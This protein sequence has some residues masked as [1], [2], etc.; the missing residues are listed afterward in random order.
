LRIEGYISKT[1]IRRW[2]S[3]YDALAAGDRPADAIP[4][5]SGPKAYDG[6]SGGRLNKI[7]LDDA[8]AQLPRLERACVSCRWIRQ[9]RLADALRR[10]G[11]TKAQY[12]ARCDD[13]VE[14]IYSTINGPRAG[15]KRLMEALAK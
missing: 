8:I 6:I 10:L 12:Y 15:V 14:A 4:T 13:A 7:M 5:H 1:N 2:L 3:N 11:L 9:L